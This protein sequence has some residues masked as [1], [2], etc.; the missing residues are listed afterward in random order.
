MHFIYE[1][2]IY[3][4]SNTMDY[5]CRCSYI[6]LDIWTNFTKSDFD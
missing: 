2:I 3:N 4:D 6:L 5:M 1:N